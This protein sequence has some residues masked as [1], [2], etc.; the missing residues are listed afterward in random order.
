MTIEN[1]PA[2]IDSFVIFPIIF[3]CG[4]ALIGI[5]IL[6]ILVF[7]SLS[8]RSVNIGLGIVRQMAPL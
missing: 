7:V 2:K 6:I 5:E 8:A 3:D 4:G 1:I